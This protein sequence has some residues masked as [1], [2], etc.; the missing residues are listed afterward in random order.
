MNKLG[1][2]AAIASIYI[3]TIIGAGFASGQEIWF[4]FSRYG[5]EGRWGLLV[6]TIVFGFLGAKAIEWGRRIGSCSYQDFLINLTG[7][8]FGYFSDLMMTTFIF[9]LT[10]VMLAGSGAVAA[11]TGLGRE[12]VCWITVCLTVLILSQH[13]EGIKGV[14]LF[15]VPLLFI[16]G[17]IIN[18]SEEKVILSVWEQTTSS[19]SW[20]LASLQYSAYNLVMALPVLVTLYRLEPDPMIL[21]WGGLIGGL[22][23]GILALL[24]YRVLVKYDFSTIDL[25]LAFITQHWKKGWRYL[26]LVALWGEL[27]TTLIA[28][29][30]A[31]ASRFNLPKNRWY[32]GKLFLILSMAV[33]ISRLGFARLI[34]RLYP[35]F[36]FFSF[37]ILL[38]LWFKPLPALEDGQEIYRKSSFFDL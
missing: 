5:T 16:M 12:M 31:L 32:L 23:L 2:I 10:G 13:L 30:Y 8:Y 26:Y 15:V 11:E 18:F 27:F 6:S 20:L 14:N 37:T 36:G 19:G 3:G 7:K 22:S 34:K 24:F 1:R 28:H 9:L 25:P 38:P 29:A 4:F 35:L 21:K 33:L 17:I